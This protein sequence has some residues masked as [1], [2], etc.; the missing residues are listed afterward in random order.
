MNPPRKCIAV[1]GSG[2]S[3]Q[4]SAYF[5]NRLHDVVLFEA[6]NYLGGH[7]NTVDVTLE[8]PTHG[9]DTGSLLYSE[10]S[11]ANLVAL[12][13]ELGMDRLDSKMSFGVSMHG[14]AL[15]WVGTSLHTECAHHA[16][17]ASPA[18]LRMMW[19]ILQ[20]NRN[21]ERFLQWSNQSARTLGQLL[22]QEGYGER[23]RD[24]YLLP[25]AAAIWSTSP[26]DI[27]G[28]PVGTSIITT[29]TARCC[30]PS[31]AAVPWL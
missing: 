22:Q 26:S 30:A 3:V 5:L 6:A 19:D 20:F 18:F 27:L 25:I 13:D 28:F 14:G 23:F 15:E 21:A 9:V 8:G 29:T 31:S 10:H 4:G 11:Y 17:A 2:I 1:I 16:N 7:T 24:V 12:F